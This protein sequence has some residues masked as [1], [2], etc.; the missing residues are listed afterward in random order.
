M[1]VMRTRATAT[2]GIN[3]SLLSPSPSAWLLARIG[4]TGKGDR[5]GVHHLSPADS[6]R[7]SR[8]QARHGMFAGAPQLSPGKRM[9]G[10]RRD[11][12]KIRWSHPWPSC[13][14]FTPPRRGSP[15]PWPTEKP[16]A[17]GKRV[18]RQGGNGAADCGWW[19]EVGGGA[20]G[21]SG[22][23]SGSKPASGLWSNLNPPQPTSWN[24]MP[25]QLTPFPLLQNPNQPTP[26]QISVQPTPNHCRKMGSVQWRAQDLEVR[27]LK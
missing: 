26:H 15:V 10:K 16:S 23:C 13:E 5:T 8:R 24:G 9:G 2:R 20:R 14:E 18:A 25:N 22:G 1:W 4:E 6:P 19:E 17:A 3:D 11:G 7:L 12:Q 27:Y 21:G